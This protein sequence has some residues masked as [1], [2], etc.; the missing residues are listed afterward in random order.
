[1]GYFKDEA[2]FTF[3]KN[4]HFKAK[5][6]M[7]AKQGVYSSKTPVKKKENVKSVTNL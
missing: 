2:E 6:F 5:G 4:D 7:N 1:L 3:G